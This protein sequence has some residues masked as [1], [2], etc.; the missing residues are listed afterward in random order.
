MRFYMCHVFF[1]IL[2]T[3]ATLTFFGID[4]ANAQESSSPLHFSGGI[5]WVR[6]LFEAGGGI[7]GEIDVSYNF[8]KYAI[9]GDYRIAIGRSEGFWD[10]NAGSLG[11]R[12]FLLE[13]NI[14]PYFG[15][16]LS[17]MGLEQVVLSETRKKIGVGIFGSIG[18]ETARK[19]KHRYKLQ[20][21]LDSPLFVHE[22][23]V[24]L[25]DEDL[26]SDNFVPITIGFSYIRAFP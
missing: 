6:N 14:S 5:Y 2:F 21:R 19:S 13:G 11:G 12:Y 4:S 8:N 23:R 17:V 24:S 10:F 16:G 15:A 7:A 3:I 18:I 22:D 1:V 26:I 25:G 9:Q 20:I